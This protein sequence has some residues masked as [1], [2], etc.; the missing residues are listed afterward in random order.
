MST[1][2]APPPDRFTIRRAGEPDRLAPAIAVPPAPET[3]A[4]DIPDMA[5]APAPAL[6]PAAPELVP[7][8]PPESQASG[9]W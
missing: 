2:V 5:G 4:P 8:G 9:K 7:A 3:A 6:S 1:R